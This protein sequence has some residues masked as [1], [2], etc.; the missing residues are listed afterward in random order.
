MSKPAGPGVKARSKRPAT[1]RPVRNPQS[2]AQTRKVLAKHYRAKHG[3][4]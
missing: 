3:V 4:R 2:T 1:L